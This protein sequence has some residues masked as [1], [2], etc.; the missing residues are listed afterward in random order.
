VLRP[1]CGGC[2]KA[3]SKKHGSREYVQVTRL[4]ETFALPEVS[5]AIEHALQLGT[6]NFDAV[7]HLMLCRIGEGR[8]VWTWRTSPTCRWPR[9]K[10]R[11]PL[12]T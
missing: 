5:H 9:Y 6:I 8:R 4:P 3:D 10:P 7:R 2:S 1:T 12:T 11:K